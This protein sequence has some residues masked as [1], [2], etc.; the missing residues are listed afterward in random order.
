MSVVDKTTL[1]KDLFDAYLHGRYHE[2][3]ST[4]LGMSLT[5]YISPDIDPYLLLPVLQQRNLP[6]KEISPEILNDRSPKILVTDYG[7]LQ[8]FENLPSEICAVL[9]VGANEDVIRKLKVS[10]DTVT[11]FCETSFS[12]QKF[13]NLLELVNLKQ[14]I[15]QLRAERDN[16]FKRLKE[17]NNIGVALTTERDLLKLGELILQKSREI[18][19]ADAGSLYIVEGDEETGKRLRFRISQNDSMEV[20]YEEFV[21][22]L[23]TASIAGYVATTGEALNIPDV[24]LLPPEQEYKFNR[25]FDE[26]TGYRTTSTLAVPMKNTRGVVLGVIQLIN[27]KNDYQAKVSRENFREV[28][29]AFDSNDEDLVSSLASQAAVALENSRLIR[30]IETLFEGFVTAS[31]TAIES[32]DP[33]TSGHSFRVAD[34]TVGLAEIV[35]KSDSGHFREIRFTGDEIK[36]MRYAGLL[37]DFGKVGV[38]EDVLV[39]AKKLYPLQLELIRERIAHYQRAWEAEYYK[40]KLNFLLLQGRDSYD[41]QLKTFDQAFKNRL[42]SLHDYL[43]F[44]EASNE[45]TVLPEGNFERLLRIAEDSEL[46]PPGVESPI[47][48]PQEAQLLSIR[49]GSLDERERIEIES[50]VIHTFVFLSKIPWTSELKRVPEIAYG[51]HEKLNGSGYPNRMTEKDIPIQTRM[52]TISDIYDALTASDRP[53]KKAVAPERALDILSSEV[54]SGHIDQ[55]LFQIFLDAK[56]YLISSR[57]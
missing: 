20:D 46:V 39:K 32:R 55:N 57:K 28:T 26:S 15:R 16:Y 49:K 25:N 2:R 45:P 12:S 35:D 53:Y 7:T 6:L 27:R 56:V 43:Q 33:T 22:P 3:A 11:D 44:I 18:T 48:S 9:L 52:M 42:N 21:M 38:R 10:E 50:H 13:L 54:K 36:E 29:R 41:V 14:Q 30:S 4:G 51:H 8:S 23:T 24:Y 5:V 34:L 31:V 47:L 17:L 19:S 40:S 37:H 1:I